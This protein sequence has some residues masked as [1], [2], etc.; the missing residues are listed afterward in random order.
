MYNILDVYKGVIFMKE[1]FFL[2]LKGI[3]LGISFILPGVSGGVLSVVMGIYDKLIEAVSHFYE[4]WASFKKYFN[5][6]FFLGI[7]GI[8]SVLVLTN[9]IEVALD[10][11]PVIT[12]LIFVGLIVGGVPQLFNIIKKDVSF[13]NILL[14]FIGIGL[15]VIMSVSTSDASNQI[16]DTSFISML[17][18]FGVGIL[19]SATIVIPGVSGSFLLMVMGYYEPLLK[20]I[21]EITSLTNLYNNVVV[22]IPFGIGLVIGAIAIAKLIDF[23]L[24]KYPIK[25]YY[26]IIGFVVASIIEVF[27][28]VFEYSY[29][30]MTMIIGLILMVMSAVIVYIFFEK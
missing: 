1:K 9:V 29:T 11:M 16:I 4:S 17:K 15:L 30:L 14:M 19:A 10:K 20:I 2:I 25:T 28:S 3:V 5:F 13:G 8:I 27:M 18:M 21:N 7:G 22:M 26:V 12:I 23:C 24:N 6:L